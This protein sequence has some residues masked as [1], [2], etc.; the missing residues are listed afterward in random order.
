MLGAATVAAACLV[1]G[2]VAQGIAGFEPTPGV[3]R[4]DVEHPTGFLTVELE[5]DA[6]GRFARTA[7]LRTAR[8][9]MEG[10]VYVSEASWS[11]R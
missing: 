6:A 2:S 5:V 1:P 3:H 11:G 8:K 9:L 7:L 4:L 10:N